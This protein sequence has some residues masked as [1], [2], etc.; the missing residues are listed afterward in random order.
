MTVKRQSEPPNAPP[1]RT[2]S[3]ELSGALMEDSE[4]VVRRVARLAITAP[5]IARGVVGDEENGD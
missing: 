1:T 2:L 4:D 5:E 3:V